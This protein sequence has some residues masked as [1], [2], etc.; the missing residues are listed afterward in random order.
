LV[1]AP[2]LRDRRWITRV[3]AEGRKRAAIAAESNVCSLV[4]SIAGRSLD[5]HVI[6]NVRESYRRT[7]TSEV[8]AIEQ[9]RIAIFAERNDQPGGRRARYI[10]KQWARAAQIFVIRVEELPVGRR[11]VITRVIAKDG[12]WLKANHCLATTPGI[13]RVCKGVTGDNK[14]IVAIA[15]DTASG[16]H[17]TAEPT[18]SPPNHTGRIIQRHSDYP[19]AIQSAITKVATIWDIKDVAD[20]SQRATLTLHRRRKGRVVIRDGR[21]HIQR[22]PGIDRSRV[23]VQRNNQMFDG[24]ATVGCGHGIQKK[25][26]RAQIDNR[27]P[28]NPHRVDVTA[29]QIHQ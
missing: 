19:T 23:Q 12:P 29:G 16:P 7:D 25:C 5:D 1:Y 15:G 8:A 2:D 22:P 14:R 17:P 21:T 3:N 9:I 11:P 24:C 26:A 27:R 10:D 4:S 13:S 20:N 28:S 18:R 6:V